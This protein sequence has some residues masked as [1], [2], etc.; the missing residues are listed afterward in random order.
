[1]NTFNNLKCYLTCKANRIET[2]N[3]TSDVYKNRIIFLTKY[4]KNILE[5]NMMMW[6]N[7]SQVQ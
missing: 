4:E 3:Q 2:H 5:T 1:M 6:A 7:G